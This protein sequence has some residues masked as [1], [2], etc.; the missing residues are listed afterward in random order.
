MSTLNWRAARR[1]ELTDSLIPIPSSPS[2][3][4]WRLDNVQ[5]AFDSGFVHIDPRPAGATDTEYPVYVLPASA[6][7]VIEY[8]AAKSGPWVASR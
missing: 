2:E 8:R 4:K 3:L 5:V 7:K 1:V 6:V